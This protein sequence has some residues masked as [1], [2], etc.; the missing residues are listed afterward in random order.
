MYENS[1]DSRLYRLTLSWPTVDY[2]TLL[3]P[4]A[5]TDRIQLKKNV[6]RDMNQEI[7]MR[8]RITRKIMWLALLPAVA[9]LSF[10][11]A[12][13]TSEGDT[14]EVVEKGSG[15]THT[16]T[17]EQINVERDGDGAYLRL[18]GASNKTIFVYVPEELAGK[19][20]NLEPRKKYIYQFKVPQGNT[21]GTMRGDLIEVATEDGKPVSDGEAAGLP[22][23]IILKGPG[24]QGQSFTVEGELTKKDE[25]KKELM[26]RAS[27]PYNKSVTVSYDDSMSETVA[28][29][30][31]KNSYKIKLKLD[32]ADWRLFGTLESVE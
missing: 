7:T 4:F 12:N 21:V 27:D 2:Q 18:F 30:E 8:N 15:K 26:F 24:A 3:E 28:G 1:D 11:G 23:Q 5:N 31:E 17:L 19:A 9:T 32:R 22:A 14:L 25:E 13:L 16:L 6:D 29:L 20:G 10:C